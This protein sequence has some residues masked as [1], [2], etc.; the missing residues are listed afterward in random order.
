MST[1]SLNG[2]FVNISCHLKLIIS[3]YVNFTMILAFFCPKNWSK[4][5]KDHPKNIFTKHDKSAFIS[6]KLIFLQ[7][8][9]FSGCGV[10]YSSIFFLKIHSLTNIWK[11]RTS[12]LVEIHT[13]TLILILHWEILYNRLNTFFAKAVRSLLSIVFLKIYNV[14]GL[15]MNA[16]IKC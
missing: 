6:R 8:I 15:V 16:H 1:C 7:N 9:D 2:Y 13:P 4:I 14:Y 11:T 5:W 3:Y 12:R 10:K